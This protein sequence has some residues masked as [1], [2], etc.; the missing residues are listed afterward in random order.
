MRL[1]WLCLTLAAC[2]TAPQK[3]DAA[4][5]KPASCPLVCTSDNSDCATFPYE[6]LPPR[7]QDIC[8]WGECCELVD[9]VW[10]TSTVECAHPARD[11]G[12]DTPADG[13]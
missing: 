8:Y 2:D 10:R 1:L 12:V 6:K 13:A 7:C 9:G 3:P 5:E 11:A 4:P